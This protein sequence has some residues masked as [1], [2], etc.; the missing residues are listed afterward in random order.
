MLIRLENLNKVYSAGNIKVSALKDVN[1][2]IEYGSFAAIVGPSGSGK[3]TLMNILGC[4]DAPSNGEYYLDGIAV[5]KMK[6]GELA[7]IRNKKIGFIFQN[8]NLLA[9]YNIFHN[10]ELPLIYSGLSGKR[11]KALVMEAIDMVGL[12]D[13][14]KHR[15]G[16]LSGGQRQRVAIARA[17]VNKPPVILADEPTG[18]L[19]SK[20]GREILDIFERII[21]EGNTI[22][23][24]THDSN[25]ASEAQRRIR[26]ADGI[27]SC[28]D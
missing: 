10:V 27:V 11:R 17:L 13:R 21:S 1:I 8:F 23:M 22:I 6:Q 24:V 14:I 2:E 5:S 28:I 16:E 25:I 7:D 18:N 3:S 12:T 15:P 19:D 4:L 9:R 20:T 26:I